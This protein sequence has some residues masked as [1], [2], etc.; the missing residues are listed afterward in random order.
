M[1]YTSML[2]TM[3]LCEIIER[4]DVY[5]DTDAEAMEYAMN[6]ACFNDAQDY[7]MIVNDAADEFSAT[8][9]GL[10]NTRTSISDSL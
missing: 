4:C 3:P 5:A 10:R 9:Q 7:M 1:R 2:I 6:Q 8:I